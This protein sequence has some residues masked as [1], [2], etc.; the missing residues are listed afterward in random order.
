MIQLRDQRRPLRGE[1]SDN[2]G[3]II[4]G[5][6]LSRDVATPVWRS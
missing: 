6:R 3:H 5:Q 1:P 2:V 4:V